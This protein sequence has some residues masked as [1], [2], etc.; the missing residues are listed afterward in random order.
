[1]IINQELIS[2][3]VPVYN[4]EKYLIRCVDSIRNQ[5]YKN[6]EIILIDDGSPDRCPEICEA[7]KEQDPRIKVIHKKN[8]GQGLARNDGLDIATGTYVTFIDSDDWIGEKHIENLYFAI[9]QSKADVA[10]GNHTKVGVTGEENIKILSLAEQ[11]YEGKCIIDNIVLPLIGTGIEK[12]SD[13]QINSSAA[14]NL[15]MVRM[16][17]Q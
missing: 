5:T 17:R 2:V 9:F 11:I 14:M 7:I 15:Y 6:L 1:M 13:V 8:A 16:L 12:C 10:I 4:V 3:V